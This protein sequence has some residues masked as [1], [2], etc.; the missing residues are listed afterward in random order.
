M[1]AV[2]SYE[3]IAAGYFPALDTPSTADAASMNLKY[4]FLIQ[5]IRGI[6]FKKSRHDNNCFKNGPIEVRLAGENALRIFV[7]KAELSASPGK[8]PF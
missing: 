3:R 1:K 4:S 6:R 7:Y 8:L 5:P 2:P